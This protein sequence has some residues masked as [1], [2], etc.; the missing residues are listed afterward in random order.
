[1][2]IATL[3]VK[4]GDSFFFQVDM[5]K[6]DGSPLIVTVD[7]IISQIKRTNDILIDTLLVETTATPGRYKFSTTPA[8]TA[9]YPIR[10][11]IL[12]IRVRD[13]LEIISTST[14]ELMVEKE[15][16]SW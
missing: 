15:V 9:T 2:A 1:M 7:N 8:K 12:D 14:I 11:L 16:S 4:R 6:A 13:G 10:E 5:A 3:N